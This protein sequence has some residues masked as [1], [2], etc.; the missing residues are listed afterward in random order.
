MVDEQSFHD[1]IYQYVSVLQQ[2]KHDVINK[3]YSQL[4]ILLKL[5]ITAVADELHDSLHRGKCVAYK[6]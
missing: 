3:H 6:G 1:K 2:S 4:V 5:Q